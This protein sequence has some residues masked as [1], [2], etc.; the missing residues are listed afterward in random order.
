M[1]AIITICRNSLC[2]LLTVALF[3]SCNSG[4]EQ[5]AQNEFSETVL[6]NGIQVMVQSVV[7][8]D[9]VGVEILYP[10]GFTVESQGHTQ[11]SH[12]VEHLLCKSAT[13]KYGAGES[14]K[15]VTEKGSATAETL[16][17]FSHFGYGVPT[18]DLGLVLSIEADR[19]RTLRIDPAVVA[20]E[21]EHCYAEV[22]KL[23]Q[24]DQMPLI[25]FAAM[26]ALQ[27]WRFGASEAKVSAGLEDIPESA[28]AAFL[29]NNYSP[30]GMLV[31]I[32]GGVSSQDA[33]A[34][35]KKHL[36]GIEFPAPRPLEATRWDR[37]PPTESMT[38]D[39]QI[40]GAFLWCDPP[41]DP[42]HRVVLSLWGNL[43][44]QKLRTDV[45]LTAISTFVMTSSNIWPLGEL[46]FFVYV[47]ARSSY[48]PTQIESALRDRIDFVKTRTTDET[49]TG[50]IHQLAEQLVQQGTFNMKLMEAQKASLVEQAGLS[51]EEAT[52]QLLLRHSINLGTRH[53]LFMGQF[54]DLVRRLQTLQPEQLTEIVTKTLDP[55]NQH[56]TILHAQPA[57]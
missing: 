49:I 2:L 41:N 26:A 5:P 46:P 40:T 53:M 32:T 42:F 7:D 50:Q 57:E 6:A 51:D 22:S 44:L 36:E 4:G 45:E 29:R 14:W 48:T 52:T 27:N 54:E 33:F 9:R 8:T 37:H 34:E 23:R 12:L 25:K 1:K 19:L 11:L 56:V 10:A 30:R 28:I 35:A 18:K 20:R 24:D 13:E 43:L 47:S 3:A 31:V 38:W 16:P 39:G 21:A 15:L 17:G 55:A